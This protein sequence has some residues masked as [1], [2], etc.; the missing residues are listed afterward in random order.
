M[1]AAEAEKPRD[2]RV[3]L[4]KTK[5]KSGRCLTIQGVA[6][7]LTDR[8]VNARLRGMDVEP[9]TRTRILHAAVRLMGREGPDRFTASALAREVGMSK[10]TLFHHFDS[11][12]EIPLAA[13]EEIFFEMVE[14]VAE[15]E[16]SLSGRLDAFAREMRTLVDNEHFLHA[17]F[18]FFIKGM[19]DPR[20]RERLSRGA[21][22]MHRR[23]VEALAPT[24]AT[25]EDPEVASRMVEV[26]LDGLALHHLAMGDHELLDRAWYRFTELLVAAQDTEDPA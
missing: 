3:I 13:L 2:A 20:F 11:L 26:M 1:L 25:G 14:D 7:G 4:V 23:T 19:F 5:N 8:S 21:F 24:L 15:G 17:Y 12:D 16:V 6:R 18:V 22:E 9:T 10:A